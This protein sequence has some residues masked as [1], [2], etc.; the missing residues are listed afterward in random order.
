MK[1]TIGSLNGKL[2][3]SKTY[4]K[5]RFMLNNTQDGK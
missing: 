3:K 4:S 1:E 5:L 2:K